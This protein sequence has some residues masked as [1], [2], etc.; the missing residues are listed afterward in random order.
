MPPG[1]IW[2]GFDPGDLWWIIPS[3]PPYANELLYKHQ[4]QEDISVTCLWIIRENL[5]CW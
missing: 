2:L 5:T 3:P 4:D 1:Y